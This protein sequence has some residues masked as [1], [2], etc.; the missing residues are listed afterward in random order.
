MYAAVRFVY[1]DSVMG[2]FCVWKRSIQRL[3]I[4][5][6]YVNVIN[7]NTKQK[8]YFTEKELMKSARYKKQ[9]KNPQKCTSLKQIRS[10]HDNL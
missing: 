3:K 4:P 5:M 6:G 8:T 10:K 1:V 2:Y 7:T 9:Q